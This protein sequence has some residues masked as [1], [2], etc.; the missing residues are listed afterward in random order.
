VE[1]VELPGTGVIFT[2]T[3][4]R[5][6]LL[7]ALAELVPYITVVVDIDDAPGVRLVSQLVGQDP[8]TVSIGQKVEVVWDDVRPGV[9]VPRFAP[10]S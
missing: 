6:A 5:K 4:T 10:S 7:P 3:V 2:F 8:D 9:T 1:W